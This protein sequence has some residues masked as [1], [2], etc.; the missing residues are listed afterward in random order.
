M[1]LARPFVHYIGKEL[2]RRLR[3]SACE[4]RDPE[5]V[6]ET[7]ERILLDE[8]AVEEAINV[9]ARE[10]LN[11]YADYMRT[12]RIPYSDM[13]HRV[14]RQILEERKVISASS[15]DGKTKV[16]REKIN[17]IS[18][19]MAQKLPRIQGAR[20]LIGWN[21]ARLLIATEMTN[22]LVMEQQVDDRARAMITN[23]ARDIPEG[24]EEYNVLHRR[25]YEQEMGRLGVDLRMPET[26]GA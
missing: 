10:L 13:F 19:K 22:L 8:L 12:N 26:P 9:E 16:S 5:A 15:R 1:I 7:F 21:D 17:E 11:Q 24:G 20:V 25:Y 3:K 2:M 23:Q 14:K 18:H 6:S 4:F